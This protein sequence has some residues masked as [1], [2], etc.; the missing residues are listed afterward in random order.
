MRML[1]PS[2]SSELSHQALGLQV[3]LYTS[4]SGKIPHLPNYLVGFLIPSGSLIACLPSVA[5]LLDG[6]NHNTH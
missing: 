2:G 1:N 6:F 5:I 3:H 4:S